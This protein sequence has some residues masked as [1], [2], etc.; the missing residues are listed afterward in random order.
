MKNPTRFPEEQKF[1]GEMLLKSA[2]IATPLL[3]EFS[4]W[5][6]AGLG[7]AFALFIANLDSVTKHVDAYAFRW[8]LIWFAISLL[9]GLIARFLSVMAVSGITA[10]QTFA[11]KAAE[12]AEVRPAFFPALFHLYFRGLLLPY[13]CLAVRSLAKVKRGDLMASSRMV[14]KTS[15]LQALLV[16]TQII[17]TFISVAVLANG[18][19][20]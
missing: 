11:A 19:K 2:A 7:A 1:A 4:A 8:A 20:V 9:A 13:R 18:I 12:L 10:N 5:L 16:L 3:S 6:M 15:Q 14:A 17:V